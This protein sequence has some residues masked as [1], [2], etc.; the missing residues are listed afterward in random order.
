MHFLANVITHLLGEA[1]D[2]DE[3]SSFH[4][5]KKEYS[6]VR[7]KSEDFVKLLSCYCLNSFDGIC[8][9]TNELQLSLFVYLSI[10]TLHNEDA[11]IRALN[12][13]QTTLT[14]HYQYIMIK[15]II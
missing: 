3:F 7:V 9:I 11:P 12:A 4:T 13:T 1:R 15:N 5:K 10:D 6:S 2:T 14:C 8:S